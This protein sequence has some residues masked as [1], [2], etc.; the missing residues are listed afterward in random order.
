MAAEPPNKKTVKKKTGRKTAKKRSSKKKDTAPEEELSSK[1]SITEEV[2]AV[3]GSE[4]DAPSAQT[5]E[6]KSISSK[7]AFGS[8]SVS[9]T[10]SAEESKEKEDTG[11]TTIEVGAA[12][13]NL[14]GDAPEVAILQDPSRKF[15]I[16]QA[17][18]DTFDF[19]DDFGPGSTHHWEISNYHRQVQV[20]DI[21]FFWKTA[22]H[23][24]IYG[25]GEIT[26][27]PK[28]M[29]NKAGYFEFNIRCSVFFLFPM[30]MAATQQALG[31]KH[32]LFSFK[33][34]AIFQVEQQQAYHLFD[35]ALLH[36]NG[37][38]G[39][40]VDPDYI[41]LADHVVEK[42][43]WLKELSR[44][45]QSL[46]LSIVSSGRWTCI[47]YA[48]PNLPGKWKIDRNNQGLTLLAIDGTGLYFETL[49]WQLALLD[50]Q[51]IGKRYFLGLQ[52]ILESLPPGLVTSQDESLKLNGGD[53][54][55]FEEAETIWKPW[56]LLAEK[57]INELQASNEPILAKLNEW[58]ENPDT[59]QLN[60]IASPTPEPPR[61]ANGLR[62]A[63]FAI[64]DGW[65]TEDLLG[66]R[67]Y[68]LAAADFLNDPRS[69]PP[70]AISIQAPWGAGKTS[71]M[72]MIQQELDPI[73]EDLN[74]R[75]EQ[76][77]ISFSQIS[78]AIRNLGTSATDESGSIASPKGWISVWF[79][80]WKYE[81]SDQ[82]WA[83][84]A[85]TIIRDIAAR[86]SPME[87][88][89]FYLDLNLRRID[90]QAIRNDIHKALL[91]SSVTWGL[92]GLAVIV[93]TL[94]GLEPILS[95]VE[96]FSS[97]YKNFVVTGALSGLL[98]GFAGYL[99]KNAES[100]ASAL[101]EYIRIPNYS[102]KQ[103]FRHTAAEDIARVFRGQ[104]DA[105]GEPVKLVIF[106]DDLDRCSP[107]KIAN[108]F[109]TINNFVA[110]RDLRCYV[111]LG[112]DG[113]IVS[114][115]LEKH[116]EDLF[117]QPPSNSQSD[118]I[119]WYY[120]D[121]FIQVPFVIPTPDPG[122]LL[123]MAKEFG[124]RHDEQNTD[125]PNTLQMNAGLSAL[126]PRVMK[127]VETLYGSI[128]LIGGY[129]KKF[130]RRVSQMRHTSTV[131][132]AA[133]LA[134]EHLLSVEDTALKRA[135]LADHSHQLTDDELLDKV[136]KVAKWNF[137]HNPR[138]I[139]RC[140]NLTR[141]FYLIHGLR[142]E[143]NEP[144]PDEEALIRWIYFAFRWPDAAR[145]V[146]SSKGATLNDKDDE[147]SL[148]Q[149]R[150][151]QLYNGAVMPDGEDSI[152]NVKSELSGQ[153]NAKQK[154]LNDHELKA[155]CRD[156]FHHIH[157]HSGKGFW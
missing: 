5:I 137:N 136:W 91:S 41:S 82:I 118:S 49:S 26:S 17:K 42:F 100:A 110:D 23:R 155:Y 142:N 70:L 121:K 93:S 151:E 20:G 45:C 99:K 124:K 109:E 56:L 64:T 40:I 65:T 33:N 48:N 106:I 32:R 148:S 113:E 75:D 147:M 120:L 85:D 35:N 107:K 39:E 138:T 80:P 77:E 139:K 141:F 24:G 16:L 18:A 117:K 69:E 126:R 1:S 58:I 129:F 154:W 46:G 71:L 90:T 11:A 108:V 3:L 81:E 116:Y 22:P 140:L 68:A 34:D 134:T 122:Q 105:A 152:W 146:Q 86:M 52:S 157:E 119:G 101:P 62:F 2:I 125:R 114:A 43:S 10:S 15:W 123:K 112:M 7:Q 31:E 84:L 143:N 83:G 131:A 88:E 37:I 60:E 28:P 19:R 30:P 54:I 156:E 4:E 133:E 79:N 21:A 67:D 36:G 115:A 145:W 59:L 87:K 103:G 132:S 73:Y 57:L 51:S 127:T 44:N 89:L 128:P 95:K 29:E 78:G 53:F 61:E 76:A 135:W 104:M 50:L 96:P 27:Q 92:V 111:V 130:K 38:F 9:N 6:P 72:K 98:M 102:E 94:A 14:E 13:M 74:R 149:R 144:V 153:L 55:S 12:Q 8:A 66:Y 63:R 97:M 150:V 47:R 25:W